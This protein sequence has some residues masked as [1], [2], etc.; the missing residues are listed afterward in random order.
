MSILSAI[1]RTLLRK[2]MR[3]RAAQKKAPGQGEQEE[4]EQRFAIRNSQVGIEVVCSGDWKNTKAPN[5][6]LQLWSDRLGLYLSAFGY[7]AEPVRWSGGPKWLFAHQNRQ[8][9]KMRQNVKA[10]QGWEK[11][12]DDEKIVFRALYQAD[13]KNTTF[14]YDFCLVGFKKKE[15]YLWLLLNGLPERVRQNRHVLDQIAKDLV[16]HDPDVEKTATG[17]G[18]SLAEQVG[19]ALGLPYEILPPQTLENALDE[20]WQTA[21]QPGIQPLLLIPDSCFLHAAALPQ[22]PLPDA[23]GWPDPMGLLQQ[24]LD[25]IKEGFMGS[26]EDMALWQEITAQGDERGTPQEN[27]GLYVPWQTVQEAGGLL[28]LRI[29]GQQPWDIFRR[30]PFG[31]FNACPDNLEQMAVS[32]YWYEG[33]GARPMMLGMDTLQFYVERPPRGAQ[34]HPLALEMFGF[35]EDLI[36]QGAESVAALEQTVR[37][38]NHWF[39]WWD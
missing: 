27:G 8:L 18:P 11:Q 3:D 32:K 20:I 35:C 12:E 15:K 21:A 38:S 33:Y 24:R 5:L 37:G 10:L 25:G 9:L 26:E 2:E 28:L 22:Y 39:F 1:A 34:A 4:R 23:Q 13:H 19:R 36:L 17:G 31:G 29:P 7:E 30:I 14:L 16:C 6:D